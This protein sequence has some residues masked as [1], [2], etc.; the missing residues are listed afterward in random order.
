MK[1]TTSNQSGSNSLP[2]W[3]DPATNALLVLYDDAQNLYG[4]TKRQ[5]F[6][7]KQVGI[8]AQGRTTILKLNYRNTEEFYDRLCLCE[9]RYDPTGDSEED[10]PLLIQPQ[11]AGRHGPPPELIKL[12]SFRH[13]ADYLAAR[14]Q[15]CMSAVHPGTRWRSS[16]ARSG[17]Q[18]R[19]AIA[20]SKPTSR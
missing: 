13:E 3:S 10:T 11:S 5:P 4:K 17:W 6:S 12:P 16:T 15:Q 2:K 7:F 14:L 1:G 9:R 18:N 19:F 20:A 8:Q